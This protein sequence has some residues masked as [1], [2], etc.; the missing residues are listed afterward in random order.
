MGGKIAEQ[1]LKHIIQD[2]VQIPFSEFK[3]QQEEEFRD[4]LLRLRS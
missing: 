4:M 1:M 3:G 2:Y